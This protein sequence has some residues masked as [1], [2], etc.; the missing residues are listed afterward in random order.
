MA[1]DG[2]LKYIRLLKKEKPLARAPRTAPLGALFS[3]DLSA[4]LRAARTRGARRRAGRAPWPAC[5]VNKGL[6]RENPDESTLGTKGVSLIGTRPDR[7]AG[8]RAVSF[9]Q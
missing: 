6:W 4:T 3:S 8:A 5:D 1:D 9:L 7:P 2:G